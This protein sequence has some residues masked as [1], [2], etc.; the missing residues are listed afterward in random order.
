MK[1]NK[2]SSLLII[3]FILLFISSA[4]CSMLMN[5]KGCE[6]KC[7]GTGIVAVKDGDTCGGIAQANGKSLQLFQSLNPN[8]PC[9]HL[10]PGEWVCVEGI[11]C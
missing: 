11:P 3:S 1:I 5:D 2:P 10:F 9:R 7:S 6:V 8:L 4:E